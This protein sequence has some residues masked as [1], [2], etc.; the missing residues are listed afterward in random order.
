MFFIL[1]GNLIPINSLGFDDEEEKI[2]SE[3]EVYFLGCPLGW[4]IELS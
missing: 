2:G 1:G 4:M 3:L